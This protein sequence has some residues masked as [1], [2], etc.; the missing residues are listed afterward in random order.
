MKKAEEDTR[1]KKFCDIFR[2]LHTKLSLLDILKG[3][4]NYA[5]YLNDVVV[6][7]RS[8]GDIVMIRG[9]PFVIKHSYN[10]K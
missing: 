6:N 3:M 7:K 1:F 4:P 8:L 10:D 2:E 5:N 9:H